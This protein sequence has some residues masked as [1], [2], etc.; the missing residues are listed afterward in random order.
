MQTANGHNEPD[1]G[2]VPIRLKANKHNLPAADHAD[3]HN[4]PYPPVVFEVGYTQTLADLHRA[5]QNWLGVGTSA[6]SLMFCAPLIFELGTTWP[7]M[8]IA[9]K[10]FTHRANGTM[11]MLAVK[12]SRAQAAVPGKY[13]CGGNEESE[14]GRM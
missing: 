10:L 9:I 7:E 8:V 6:L 1:D 2:I 5:A 3:V 13:Y 11:A 4:N 12:Y 14:N